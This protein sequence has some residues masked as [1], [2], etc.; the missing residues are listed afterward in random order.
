M[1]EIIAYSTFVIAMGL[2]ISRPRVGPRWQ[3]GP[4]AAALAGVAI[5]LPFGIVGVSDILAAAS[6]LWRPFLTIVAIMTMTAAARRLGVLDCVAEIVFRH[7]GLTIHQLFLCVY[8]LSACT[9]SLLNNDAAVLLLTPLVVALVQ[10]RYPGQRQLLRPF[11]FVV[12]MAAGVAP[13]VVSNPMNMIVAS[14]AGLD[15][16]AYA[17]RMIPIS[18][19]GWIVAFLVLQHLFGSTLAVADRS[20]MT[21]APARPT[22]VQGGMLILLLAVLGSCP[23][24]TS[25]DPAAIWMVSS[26]GAIIA[27]TLAAR[28]RDVNVRELVTRG[29]AWEVLI[30]LLA[31]FV[32]AVGL[33]NVGLVRY[34]SALYQD[35]GI[36]LVGLTAAVGSALLNNHPMAIMNLLALDATPHAGQR[37]ILAALIGG[38]LGPRLLPIGSLAGLLWLESC[39]RLGVEISLAQFVRVGFAVTVPTLVLSLAILAIW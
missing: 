37:E 2:A 4:G 15:F 13:F 32:I 17:V 33:R 34:L 20:V 7:P 8:V 12:F 19:A 36:A 22:A 11:A 35:A 16:N 24:M 18:L 14:S 38:D 26:A 39:R 27:V 9:A 3:V 28:Q 30:F 21:S 10:R 1:R 5:L 29:I 25:I 23:V 6:T 31:V